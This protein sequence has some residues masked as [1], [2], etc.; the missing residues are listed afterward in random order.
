MTGNEVTYVFDDRLDRLEKDEISTLF[1]IYKPNPYQC[2]EV[3]AG[4]GLGKTCHLGNLALAEGT[5]GIQQRPQ[6]LQARDISEG[7]EDLADVVDDL[8]VDVAG[9]H[10]F[11][12][13]P[14]SY[15]VNRLR[16]GLFFTFL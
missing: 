8:V 15:I 12:I 6:D 14:L 7:V 4:I 13:Q 16:Q 1:P 11:T 10:R 3:F 5:F 9:S 2:D